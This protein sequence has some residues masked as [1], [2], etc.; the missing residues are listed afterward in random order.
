V[1]DAD[2]TLH[3]AAGLLGVHYMTAYRYVRL[4]LLPARKQGGIWRVGSGDLERLRSGGPRV[5]PNPRGGRQR[6][7]W[8][9]RFESRL[10]AGDARGAWSVVE[11]AMSAGAEVDEVVLAIISPAMS[12]IGE[13]W[14]RGELD[15]ADEHRASGVATRVVGRLGPRFVRRGRTRGAVVIGTPAGD[16]H[17]LPAAMAS[18]LVRM[19]GWDVSDLGADVPDAS[20]VHVVSTTPD[21]VAVG[22]SVMTDASLPAA[23]GLIAALRSSGALGAGVVLVAGGRAVR[24][25]A[26]AAALGADAVTWDAGSFTTLLDRARDRSLR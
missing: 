18:D 16:R 14:Q 2:L 12:S 8:A 1:A 26:A 11:A 5:A 7:P 20:F 9:A 19:E 23:A 3:Q 13:R 22:I 25:A 6:A 15:I 10:V 17:A 21:L 4:G 24:D